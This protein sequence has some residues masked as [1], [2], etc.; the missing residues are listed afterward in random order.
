MGTQ[1]KPDLKPYYSSV[2]DR[3]F[4]VHVSSSSDNVAIHFNNFSPPLVVE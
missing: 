4:Q 2:D 3:R 1:K